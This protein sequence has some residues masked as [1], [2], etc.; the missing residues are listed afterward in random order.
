MRRQRTYLISIIYTL[1]ACTSHTPAPETIP[2]SPQSTLPR[3]EAHTTESNGPW[4]FTTPSVSHTYRSTSLTTIYEILT[5]KVRIDTVRLDT[6]FT[7]SRGSLHAATTIAGHIDSLRIS[8]NANFSAN[9]AEIK[10][11]VVFTGKVTAN[12]LVLE[13]SE[14]EAQCSSP[15]AAILGEVRLVILSYPSPLFLNSAWKDST[16]TVTCSGTQIPTTLQSVSSYQVSGKTTYA[17]IHALVIQR[18]DSTHFAG[19]G[20]QNQHQLEL[21]GIGVS[22]ATIYLDINTGTIT[23]IKAHQKT[24]MTIKASG[25]ERRFSQ[26]VTQRVD[27]VP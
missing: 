17:L 3:T 20:I 23:L 22:F 2:S 12:V 11:P 5:P 9:K 8:S 25:K 18:I 26:E 27:L 16:S 19:H 1:T 21:E 15:M 14:N 24:N 6:F 7:I 13:P 10:L 4:I